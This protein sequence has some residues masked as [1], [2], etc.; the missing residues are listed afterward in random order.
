MESV[1][2]FIHDVVPQVMEFI[3][4]VLRPLSG[5][6]LFYGSDLSNVSKSEK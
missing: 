6:S 2:D 5:Y 3:P 1:V 4:Y